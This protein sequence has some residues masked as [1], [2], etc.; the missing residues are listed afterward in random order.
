MR[1][2]LTRAAREGH[3][4]SWSALA[5]WATRAVLGSDDAELVLD[6]VEE[7]FDVI[8]LAP[9]LR[10]LARSYAHGSRDLVID[11]VLTRCEASVLDDADRAALVVLSEPFR[12]STLR[13]EVRQ[14]LRTSASL[15]LRR[16]ENLVRTLE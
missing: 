2:T 6:V 5:A 8:P 16:I 13:D 14:G 10:L 15:R 12:P 1:A 11:R 4:V 7:P 9:L 3:R